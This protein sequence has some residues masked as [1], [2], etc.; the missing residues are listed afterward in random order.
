MLGTAFELATAIFEFQKE[1]SLP[2]P[3]RKGKKERERERKRERERERE[4]NRERE[5]K[6]GRKE[7][8]IYLHIFVPQGPV[9]YLVIC[10]SS[11]PSTTL[12]ID[13][14]LAE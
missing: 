12:D 6:E 14:R 4:R 13:W 5:R 3:V 1:F 8:G 7:K 9:L 2:P 10:V 11:V